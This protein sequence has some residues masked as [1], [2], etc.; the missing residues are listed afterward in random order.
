MSNSE[1]TRTPAYVSYATFKNK[2]RQLA[3]E[4]ALPARIDPSV[5][6]GMSGSAQRQFLSALRFFEFIDANGTPSGMLRKL[7]SASDKEWKQL[8]G[9]CLQRLYK[10][11]LDALTS[12]TPKQLTDAFGTD[13]AGTT[14]TAAVRFLLEAAKDSGVPV[15]ARIKVRGTPGAPPRPRVQTKRRSRRAATIRDVLPPEAPA[16][17]SMVDA[18]LA[19]FPAFNPEWPEA[20]QAAWFKAYEKLLAMNDKRD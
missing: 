12:G 11:Q 6:A 20:Q 3:V 17:T 10:D 2:I 19:K 15:S 18:L 8:L 7:A 9:E 5:L 16:A 1:S 13:I 4:G 14:R